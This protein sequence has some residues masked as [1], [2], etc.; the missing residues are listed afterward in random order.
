MGRMR[1]KFVR[2]SIFQSLF[3]SY[4]NKNCL[5]S[6]IVVCS[7]FCG[8]LHF[9]LVGTFLQ[10]LLYRD[11]SVCFIYGKCRASCCFCIGQCSLTAHGSTKSKHLRFLTKCTVGNIFGC[12]LCLQDRCCLGNFDS[13]GLCGSFVTAG[14]FCSDGDLCGS[15]SFDILKKEGLSANEE[16]LNKLV[17]NC[18]KADILQLIR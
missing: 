3:H 4:S 14:R 17:D 1:G 6:C 16:Q 7:R 13:Q 10:A 11:L 18:M 5:C 9:D 15:G 8:N 12:D 2:L